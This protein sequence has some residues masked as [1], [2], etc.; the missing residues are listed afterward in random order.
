[1]KIIGL[2]IGLLLPI[3]NSEYTVAQT[4]TQSNKM[5]L[6]M[7][8]W[9]DYE[10]GISY[11]TEKEEYSYEEPG[12]VNSAILS[13]WNANTQDYEYESKITTTYNNGTLASKHYANYNIF[14]QAWVD[15]LKRDYS[16][17]EN[18]ISLMESY[19]YSEQGTWEKEIKEE[20]F[21]DSE[22]NLSEFN[23]YE[24]NTEN[25]DW[26][27]YEKNTY[28]YDSNNNIIGYTS[29][30]WD[31][32]FDEWIYYDKEEYQY[33]DVWTKYKYS[34]WN[35][36]KEEWVPVF[37]DSSTYS[38]D[39]LKYAYLSCYWKNS[40]SAW[41]NFSKEIHELNYEGRV[42]LF[43]EYEWNE[44]TLRW[45]YYDKEEYQYDSYGN[46]SLFIDYNK[47][48]EYNVWKESLKETYTYNNDYTL[49]Q[50]V[51]PFEEPVIN[52]V[53]FNTMMVGIHA[54]DWNPSN[55]SWQHASDG[56]FFYETYEPRAISAIQHSINWLVYPSP[57]QDQLFIKDLSGAQVE[58]YDLNGR[59]VL[60][61]N[62]I[63]GFQCIST[64]K[65]KPGIYLLKITLPTGLLI[66]RK[67]M[68]SY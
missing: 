60:H 4:E 16:Y 17:T 62:N 38:T 66:T 22:G 29:W 59:S 26:D 45:D 46:V 31:F 25:N 32:I 20:Y 19:L 18:K 36:L 33:D 65:I 61:E 49:D 9:E 5:S 15:S 39:G 28:N 2:W 10:S 35:E 34:E 67:V 54:Y 8:E 3:L 47:S 42:T 44:I 51:L 52:D 53:Y 58:L 1:M 37:K 40:A 27:N 41:V 13:L 50:L 68:K 56:N 14:T 63:S 21:Y 48:S 43:T 57:F 23:F 6:D 55:S 24:W 12:V 7:M 30:V 64:Q 11:K